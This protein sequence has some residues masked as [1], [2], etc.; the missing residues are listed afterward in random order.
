MHLRRI[1]LVRCSAHCRIDPVFLGLPFPQSSVQDRVV[2]RRLINQIAHPSMPPGLE[3][4]W[5]IF[6]VA[7][8]NPAGP[9]RQ[10]LLQVFKV[11][12]AVA[13]CPDESASLCVAYAQSTVRDWNFKLPRNRDERK[14]FGD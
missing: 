11:F 2:G 9:Q 10:L 14:R 3:L 13:V 5:I 1:R 6:L 7:I 4:A 8:V 12:V